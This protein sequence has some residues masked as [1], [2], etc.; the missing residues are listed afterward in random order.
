[1]CLYSSKIKSRKF[2][3]HIQYSVHAPAF[4]GYPIDGV[5]RAQAV[6]TNKAEKRIDRKK[7]TI[8]PA[9]YSNH[10]PTRKKKKENKETKGKMKIKETK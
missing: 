7:T 6:V 3:V 9:D 2:F 1:M 8:L 4:V 10:M 5:L